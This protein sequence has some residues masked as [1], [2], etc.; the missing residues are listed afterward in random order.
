MFITWFLI[1]VNSLANENI[2]IPVDNHM[3]TLKIVVVNV[4]T[5]SEFSLSYPNGMCYT[6]PDNCDNL[7]LFDDKAILSFKRYD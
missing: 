1:P 7:E 2:P 4:A 5:E 6:I 3:D